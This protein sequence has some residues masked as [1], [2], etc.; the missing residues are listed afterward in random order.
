MRLGWSVCSVLCLYWTH[1]TLFA[2]QQPQA[3][4][5]R[6]PCPFWPGTGVISVL[7]SPISACSLK[8]LTR[9]RV[10]EKELPFHA[11]P[12]RSVSRHLHLS[13]FILQHSCFPI[14]HLPGS[15]YLV[16]RSYNLLPSISTRCL[17][18]TRSW[19]PLKTTDFR[20]WLTRRSTSAPALR[21]FPRR[22]VALIFSKSIDNRWYG[23]RNTLT[24]CRSWRRLLASFSS[25]ATLEYRFSVS[26][27]KIAWLQLQL[28]ALPT[29]CS[30]LQL[31]QLLQIP[32]L[33]RDV[34]SF[35]RL[36][37]HHQGS[38]EADEGG[39]VSEWGY[40]EKK[41]LK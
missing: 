7:V 36:H 13:S 28:V 16:P 19:F 31:L 24:I 23:S 5:Q 12:S 18:F 41:I 2:L 9:E 15:V 32:H 10:H 33:C 25:T 40:Y 34:A 1:A 4:I 6:L 3:M 26:Y 14:T 37:R 35:R 20:K 29:C 21:R 11:K 39:N 17:I 30:L 38:G 27:C 8:C 22:F